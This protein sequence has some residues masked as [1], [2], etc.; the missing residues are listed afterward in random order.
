MS[1]ALCNREEVTTFI[2]DGPI[3]AG[4]CLALYDASE[5]ATAGQRLA[6]SETSG[7]DAVCSI[8]VCVDCAATRP[9]FRKID[10]AQP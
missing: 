9:L 4:H 5:T 10:R 6:V 8:P 7:G 3:P 1:C 2:A